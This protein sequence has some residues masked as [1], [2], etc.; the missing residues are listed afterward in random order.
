MGYAECL[1]YPIGNKLETSLFVNGFKV[2]PGMEIEE[3]EPQLLTTTHL[4]DKG[5]NALL[6]HLFV[7]IPHVDKVAI[8]GENMLGFETKLGH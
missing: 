5:I 7:G 2:A 8:V 3:L 6:T 4:V 1:I